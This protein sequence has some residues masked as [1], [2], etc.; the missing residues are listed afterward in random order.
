MTTRNIAAH[1]T[2]MAVAVRPNG[3]FK[4]PE[5]LFRVSFNPVLRQNLIAGPAG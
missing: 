5:P 4:E 2:L 3:T 1:Q